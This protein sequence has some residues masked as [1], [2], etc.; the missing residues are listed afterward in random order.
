VISVV[1]PIF[2]ELA[3]LDALEVRLREATASLGTAV[4]LILVDDHSTDG[5]EAR[6]S[7]MPPPIRHLRLSENQGQWVATTAGLRA[8]R[9]DIVVVLDGDLQDPPE[10]IPALVDRLRTSTADVVF[11][12][13]AR[14]I[15]PMWFEVGRRGY[16]LLQFTVNAGNVMPSGA[17]SYCAMHA[18]VAAKVATIEM[19]RLNLAAA[20]IALRVPFETLHYNRDARPDGGSRVGPIGLAR[21]ALGSLLLLSPLGRRWL[22]SAPIGDDDANA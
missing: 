10:L 9:G 17:G 19:K 15:E 8:A 16:R 21:E 13:K 20:L 18:A 6:L 11:A 12:T 2:N 3:V 14:R 4:E 1:I 5:S 7:R 22:N